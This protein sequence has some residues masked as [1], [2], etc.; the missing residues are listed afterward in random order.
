MSQFGLLMGCMGLAGGVAA[1]LLT[2]Y[3]DKI[4]QKWMF[5]VLS[6]VVAFIILGYSFDVNRFWLYALQIIYGVIGTAHVAIE[7]ALVSNLTCVK[8]RGSQ[9]GLHRATISIVSALAMMGSGYLVDKV[10]LN[11][12]FYVTTGFILLAA[13]VSTFI[14]PQEGQ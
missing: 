11:V 2:S 7:I 12:V 3:S 6:F 4:G 10:G 5:S 14:M 8:N 9:I 1:Y 13:I